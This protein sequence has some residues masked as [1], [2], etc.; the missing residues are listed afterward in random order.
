MSKK[1]EED[2]GEIETNGEEEGRVY[3]QSYY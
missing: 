1:K 2:G 3:E